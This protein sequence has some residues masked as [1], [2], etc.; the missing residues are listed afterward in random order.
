LLHTFPNNPTFTQQH[1]LPKHNTP[2]HALLPT[3][4]SFFRGQFDKQFASSQTRSSVHKK[5]LDMDVCIKGVCKCL[6]GRLCS[7]Y[8]AIIYSSCLS[9]LCLRNKLALNVRV[10]FTCVFL[11]ISRN[12]SRKLEC[13]NLWQ[14]YR[15]LP[16]NPILYI[17]DNLYLISCNINYFSQSS[18]LCV[19]SLLSWHPF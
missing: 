7:L 10:F 17:R 5:S 1:C 11:L 15:Q 19:A 4:Y 8:G 13:H 16:S 14:E 6:C 12:L 2:C 18:V 3:S 9:V